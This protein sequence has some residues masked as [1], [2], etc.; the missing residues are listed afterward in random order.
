M[1]RP[2]SASTAVASCPASLTSSESS[3]SNAAGA[4][5]LHAHGLVVR[6]AE[7]F[8][9]LHL[10][11]EMRA[12][13][14]VERGAALRRRRQRRMRGAAD[15]RDRLR[16]EQ[17]DRRRGTRWS[18][19][20]R[21]QSRSP[22]AARE[23]SRTAVPHAEGRSRGGLRQNAVEPPGHVGQVF[24]V[25][26]RDA[27]GAL[28]RIRPARAALMQQRRGLGPVDRLGDAGRLGQRLAPQL[29]DR[30]DDGARGALRRRSTRASSRCAPRA[31]R[32][33]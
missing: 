1:A 32:S 6:L 2:T 26:E 27:D 3:G 22:A 19:R 17:A 29:P 7:R 25:L 14:R 15:V 28:E 4:L 12:E 23:T 21:P 8:A 30:R 31:R 9:F 33:G 10:A 20:A 11:E 24:L 18:A 5:L 13:Q 16:A